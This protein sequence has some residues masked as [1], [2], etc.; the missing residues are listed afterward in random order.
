V[1]TETVTVPADTK[2][3]AR[4]PLWVTRDGQ[5]A[6]EPMGQSGVRTLTVLGGAVGPVALVI[7]LTA[8]GA[9]ARRSL[10]KRRMAAWDAEWR[11]TG[12]RWTTRA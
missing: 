12:P 1:R 10:D 7:L 3:G 6:L 11:A 4:I 9:L 8:S 2:A 5:P